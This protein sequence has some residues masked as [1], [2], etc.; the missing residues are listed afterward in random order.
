MQSAAESALRP[1]P[2]C[3]KL[4]A[5]ADAPRGPL[6]G[7][8]LAVAHHDDGW[9]E[10][11]HEPRSGDGDGPES[12]LELSLAEHLEVSGESV[13]LAGDLHPYAEAIVALHGAWLHGARVVQ[14][15]ELAEQRDAVIG[16]WRAL[17]E[18]RA[19]E[20]GVSSADLHYDQRLC[21]MVDFMSLWLCGWPDGDELALERP[22]G[23]DTDVER[24]GDVVRMPVGL[25]PASCE[26]LVP[27]VSGAGA[28]PFPIVGTSVRTLSLVAVA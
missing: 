22:S 24:D 5:I 15:P 16:S 17:A 21:A 8:R 3:G 6:E 12:F 28:A 7:F 10:R 13:R 4:A 9:A 14:D 25:L 26:L 2:R 27:I 18:Q 11:D 23:E 1:P 20:L 19:E